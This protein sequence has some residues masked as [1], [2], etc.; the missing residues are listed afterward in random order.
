MRKII[1]IV[2]AFVAI[3]GYSQR[4][5]GFELGFT[6]SKSSSVIQ[7]KNFY[8][9]TAIQNDQSVSQLLEKNMVFKT[10]FKNQQQAIASKLKSCKDSLSCLISGYQFNDKELADIDVELRRLMKDKKELQDFVKNNLRPSGK[11]E[12]FK[13]STDTE[14]IVNA[15]QLCAQAMNRIMKVYGLGEAAQYA[16]IDSVSYDVE[17]KFYKGS[18]FMWSDLLHNKK[19]KENALFF[20]E[21]LDFSLSLLYMNHR[22]EVARYEPLEEKENKKAIAHIKQVDFN[23]FDYASILILGNGP[24]NYQDRLSAIGKLN[25]QLGV[26]EYQAKKAP[27]IIV[28]GGHAHPF[29][30]TF[31]EAIE[32]KKELMEVYHIPE[33]NILIDP[34]ARHTT[35]NLRNASRLMIAYQM[36]LDKKSIVVTNVSHSDYVGNPNFNVR[37]KEELGY[38]PAIILKRLNSTALEFLPNVES[39]HQNP[40]DPLDP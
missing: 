26:L 19:P 23:T 18:V 12:N 16:T 32:M 40:I 28:S 22:Y 29:R 17:S 13:N 21:S 4:V 7:D 39:L 10:I 20:Q 34:F 36:P 14:L 9:L 33:E 30:A 27:F 6:S 1:Y 2:L 8:L 15:W 35:T 5:K 38:L 31:C 3:S 25:L 37:C 24:E 11:Y